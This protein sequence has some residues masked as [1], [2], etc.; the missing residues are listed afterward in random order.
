ML[1][2]VNGALMIMRD[3]ALWHTSALS[4]VSLISLGIDF[5]IPC[6]DM[7]ATVSCITGLKRHKLGPHVPPRHMKEKESTPRQ[8]GS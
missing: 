8:D 2:M 5:L 7:Y 4:R 6:L 3:I 1:A